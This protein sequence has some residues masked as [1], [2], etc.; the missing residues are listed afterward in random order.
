[1]KIKSSFITNSSS[2]NFVLITIRNTTRPEF[3][4]FIEAFKMKYCKEQSGTRHVKELNDINIK[5]ERLNKVIFSYWTSML[6]D[7]VEDMPHFMKHL[8]ISH[9]LGE[10]PC[11]DSIKLTIDSDS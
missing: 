4:D 8:I 3:D 10:V 1:M 7:N 5:H 2:A 11:V 6:N 9:L